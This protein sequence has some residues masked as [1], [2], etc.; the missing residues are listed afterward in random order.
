MKHVSLIIVSILLVW[1]SLSATPDVSMEVYRFNSSSSAY[2]EVSIYVAGSSLLCT[3]GKD[4]EYGVEYIVMVKDAAD[5]IVAGHKYRLSREGC[6]AKDIFDVKRFTLADGKYTVEVETNDLADTASHV[7]VSQEIDVAFGQSNASLSD[8]QILAAL[9]SQPDEISPLHKSGLY[10]EPLAFRLYYP[11][12]SQLSVYLES[13]HAD[14]LEGQPYLQYTIKPITGEIPPPI[15]TYKKVKKEP[16]A[17]NVF[18]LD[19]KNLI[20]GTY[21]LEAALYD[22][23]KQ[24]KET[25]QVAFTRLN[26]TGD[27]IFMETAALQLESS[28]VNNIP[29]DSLDYDLKAIAPIISSLDIEVMNTLLKKGSAKSKRY[30]LH[31]YWTTLAGKHA[32]VAFESYMDVAKLVDEMFR[33][34]FG[35][36]FETD[37]GHVFLKYGKPNDVITV[38]DE[39]SAPPYE[40]WFYNTFPATH[41]NNVRFLFYN[42]SLTRNGHELLHST[43]TGEVTNARWE[44]ELY[45]DATQET[46]G[47]NERVM[48]DNVHRNARTY[49]QN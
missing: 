34:G 11:A 5:Q 16:I 46:P 42:P 8:L 30:F 28:F 23:N 24:L 49:F 12:L 3:A 19:I 44:T 22:G 14:Q 21:M 17:A 37:R 47:V 39:P 18:Q 26:P 31:K 38:E 13:Y 43:A 2:I 10:L 25:K 4:T 48:G 6:P 40:I 20:T 41:Q 9:K 1:N 29:E 45:R 36:G 33:S 32:E 7:S 27:S 15:V 35:Y